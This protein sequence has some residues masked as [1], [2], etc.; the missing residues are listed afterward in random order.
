MYY[1]LSILFGLI[2]DVLYFTLFLTYVKNL[3]EKRIMLFLL[4]AISYV[5]CMIIP[6]YDILCYLLFMALVYSSL[7]IL[8]KTKAQIIDVFIIGIAYLWQVILSLVLPIF[9]MT[10]LSNYYILYIINL[11]LLFSPFIFKNKFHA[12]YKNIADFGIE[13]MLKK[14]R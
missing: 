13:M 8:Y 14:G 4:I 1:I 11:V 12:M 7:K 10:D 5:V 6:Q 9:A 2:P 3:K